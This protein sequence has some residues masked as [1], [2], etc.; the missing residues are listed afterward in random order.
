MWRWPQRQHQVSDRWSSP[1][2]ALL[3]LAEAPDGGPVPLF[4]F[5]CP[6]VR[7][8]WGLVALQPRIPLTTNLQV[9]SLY[10]RAGG[11]AVY[12]VEV[13]SSSGFEQPVHFLLNSGLLNLLK[14]SVVNGTL[15]SPVGGRLKD[16]RA[17]HTV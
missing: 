13:K 7:A 8:G 11:K 6:E 10:L 9:H 5:P 12:R 3:P 15:V 14:G 1:P 16:K 4:L 17:Q 2:P